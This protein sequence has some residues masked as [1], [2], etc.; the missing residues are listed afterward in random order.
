VTR[1]AIS[2]VALAA[3]F[4]L[5]GCETSGTGVAAT[6]PVTP[7][8]EQNL[9]G[10]PRP[11][12]PIP[13]PV[14]FVEG[15][16]FV[17][18]MTQ[19]GEPVLLYT[20]TGGG[21]FFST[22]AAER[23]GLT[24]SPIEAD[25]DGVDVDLRSNVDSILLP[26]FSWDAWIPP[27]EVLGGRMP[28]RADAG[29]NAFGADGL[30]GQGWFKGRVWTFDYGEGQLFLRAPGDLPK[31]EAVHG[32]PLFF[33]SN[34]AG[35]RGANYPRITVKIDGEL[36]D[37]LFD[38]GAT[39]TL[40]AA[41]LTTIGD[42]RPATRATSFISKTTFDKWAEKHPDW[43]KIE[44]ADTS[45]SCS[46]S[47]RDCSAAGEAMIEVPAIEVGGFSVGP[48]WFTRRADKNFHEWMSQWMDKKID[49]ALGGSALKYFRVHVDYPRGL[50]VFEKL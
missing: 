7:P 31:H 15:R 43:R 6:P 9:P 38:T 39:V 21:L 4:A 41:A 35:E 1:W 26:P 18:P 40:S 24:V 16:F 11:G 10:K 36:V 23:L 2:L 48:V 45:V 12:H 30:L 14:K 19:D 25:G 42:G 46:G 17:E 3:V 5:S 50:A 49:G 13:L 34:A 29:K 44:G 27:P 47:T 28:V 8:R 22:T 20:D 33:Q 32:V 37:L